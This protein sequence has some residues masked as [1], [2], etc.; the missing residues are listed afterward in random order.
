MGASRYVCFGTKHWTKGME[1]GQKRAVD[2]YVKIE[3]QP[4]APVIT[5]RASAS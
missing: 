5:S 2:W 4:F 1:C 3:T